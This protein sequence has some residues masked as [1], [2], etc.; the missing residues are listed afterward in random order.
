MEINTYDII[1]NFMKPLDKK[2]KREKERLK[3]EKLKARALARKEKAKVKRESKSLPKKA[4]MLWS[5]AVRKLGECSY[6]GSRENLNAHHIF[7]RHN[8]S[9]RWDLDNGICLC[10]KHHVFS[11]QFSA[12]KTPTEF[13][14]WLEK[15][16]SKE[17]LEN[18]AKKANSIGQTDSEFLKATIIYLQS[19]V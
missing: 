14:Y 18:L 2:A 15:Q 5:L 12:H 19:K 4:D 8:K 10:A 6:C 17:W 1:I 9:V 11:D 13:T 3:R 16:Y 7:S